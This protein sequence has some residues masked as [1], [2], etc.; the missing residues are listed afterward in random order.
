MGNIRNTNKS[1]V[2]KLEKAVTH[3]KNT[4]AGG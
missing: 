2:G 4:A 3:E 1:W